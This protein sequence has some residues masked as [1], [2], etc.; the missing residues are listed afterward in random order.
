MKPMKQGKVLKTGQYA[1]YCNIGKTEEC[2]WAVVAAVLTTVKEKQSITQ[3]VAPFV[4][5]SINIIDDRVALEPV[6]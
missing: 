2:N 1:H 4:F 5:I 6:R 3:A